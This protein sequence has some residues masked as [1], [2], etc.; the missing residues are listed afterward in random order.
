[1]D[2]GQRDTDSKVSPDIEPAGD[3]LPPLPESLIPRWLAAVVLL[4]LIASGV[5][6]AWFI[7]SR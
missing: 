3:D 4:L 1:M 7:L 5:A 6:T 2:A